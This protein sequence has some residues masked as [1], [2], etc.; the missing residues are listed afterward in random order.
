M[1]HPFS[2]AALASQRKRVAQM[3]AARPFL[4]VEHAIA[5]SQLPV[6]HKTELWTLAWSLLGA[7][8]QDQQLRWITE[9]A[10]H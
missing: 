1:S 4:E 10:A 9:Q 2:P 5:Y 7:Q 6:E 3:V 8:R